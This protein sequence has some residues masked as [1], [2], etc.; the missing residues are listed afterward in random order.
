MNRRQQWL[1]RITAVAREY[2]AAN[3]ASELLRTELEGNPRFGSGR[4]WERRD[5]VAFSENLQATY[6]IRMYAVFEA[7]LR[8]YWRT[9]RNRDTRPSMEQLVRHAIP[10]QL[11]SQDC[12]DD[13][14]DVREYRNLLVHDIDE[15]RAANPASF[16]MAE[17]RRRLCSYF[18]R[19]DPGWQ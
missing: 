14:D 7:G 12:I 11:F 1:E 13:A 2:L 10:N 4:D 8:A 16:T 15:A 3:T 9:H 18:A 6:I 19:L 5:G 17:A